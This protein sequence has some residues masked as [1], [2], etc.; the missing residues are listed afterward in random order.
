MS[1]SQR[2]ADRSGSDDRRKSI[3]RRVLTAQRMASRERKEDAPEPPAGERD[4]PELIDEPT[5]EPA[6]DVAVE[7]EGPTLIDEAGNDAELVEELEQALEDAQQQVAEYEKVLL[8]LRDAVEQ[9]KSE[10]DSACERER[11]S[12]ARAKEIEQDLARVR[13][14]LSEAQ[15]SAGDDARAATL[16]RQAAELR[17]EIDGLR[18]ECD[19]ARASEQSAVSR[20]SATEQEAIRLRAQLDQFPAVKLEAERAERLERELEDLRA[21]SA[22]VTAA[23]TRASTAA[24]RASEAELRA[25]ASDDRS[26]SADLRADAAEARSTAA[27]G[28]ASAAEAQAKAADA[29]ATAA[30]ARAVA[31]ETRASAAEKRAE[32][33]AQAVGGLE[34]KLRDVEKSRAAEADE[35]SKVAAVAKTAGGNE[36][37]LAAEV[38]ALR[39]RVAVAEE[40]VAAA[41]RELGVEPPNGPLTAA[42][43]MRAVGPLTLHCIGE[44]TPGWTPVA[45]ED[46]LAAA[47]LTLS[48]KLEERQQ[49]VERLSSAL[50]RTGGRR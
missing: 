19:A 12:V 10:F 28:R 33:A 18:T 4:V 6:V 36:A 21:E 50:A 24:K 41:L 15:K 35:A 42:D 13:A 27:E 37:R 39:Q 5:P 32:S 34:T 7:S 16:V 43:V 1:P 30:E 3:F 47:V 2:D 20:S 9:V 38:E 8:G 11:T 48:Q 23:E 45:P 46:T 25:A 49:Q 22:S 40:A 44:G 14:E 17:A 29:R 26:T 31:A